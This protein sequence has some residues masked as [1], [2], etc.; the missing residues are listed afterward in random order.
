M[1]TTQEKTEADLESHLGHV[2]NSPIDGETVT[3]E[4]SCRNNESSSS[5]NSDSEESSREPPSKKKKRQND[6]RVDELI[7]Q[8]GYI[9]NCLSYMQSSQAAMPA[10]SGGGDESKSPFLINPATSKP[11]FL[12]EIQTKIDDKKTIKE[13]P[14]E[15]IETV[16]KLQHF[17]SDAWK[18]VKYSKV[19]QG[20]LAT[21][22]FTELRVNNE[23][24][25]LN[26]G[27][28]YLAQTER[29]IADLTNALLDQKETVKSW[30]T[31][32]YRLGK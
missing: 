15:R 29:V 28:D 27:K 6:P 10:T 13:T 17:S 31:R 20:F 22:G 7:N 26:R 24:C 18:E 12:G 30:I 3:S 23:L 9:A 16:T 8:V 11:L 14:R 4:A 5:S 32:D 25:H 19:L 21:P 1:N 2:E